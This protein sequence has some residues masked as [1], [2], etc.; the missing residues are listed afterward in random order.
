[1]TVIIE[2]LL[3]AGAGLRRRVSA[4][5][6]SPRRVKAFDLYVVVHTQPYHSFQVQPVQP[7]T[8]VLYQLLVLT[9]PKMVYYFND[10]N[11]PF[12]LLFTKYRLLLLPL[13]LINIQNGKP[14]CPRISPYRRISPSKCR[15]KTTQ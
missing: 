4:I 14:K 2:K 12:L 6:I 3:T 1:V 9:K 11:F 5:S 8:A 15:G 10:P 13:K 7:W